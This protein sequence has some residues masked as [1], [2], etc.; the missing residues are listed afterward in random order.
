MMFELGWTSSSSYLPTLISNKIGTIFSALQ[1]SPTWFPYSTSI[2]WHASRRLRVLSLAFGLLRPKQQSRHFHRQ[3]HS[4]YRRR[5][6]RRTHCLCSS[7]MQ[8]WND[9]GH[10]RYSPF[11]VPLQ[12]R[13]YSSPFGP[14]QRRST[15]PFCS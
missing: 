13:V 4:P 1:P 5:S 12:R 11:V 10:I 14:N 2:V 6:P 7:S 15:W 3:R 8:M 9:G